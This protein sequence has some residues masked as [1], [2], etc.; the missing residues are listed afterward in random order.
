[1]IWI[2]LDVG[3]LLL[4]V[5]AEDMG[6]F[7]GRGG[8]NLVVLAVEGG[9][10]ASAQRADGGHFLSALILQRL[11]DLLVL[12]LS[13]LGVHDRSLLLVL[14]DLGASE[15]MLLFLVGRGQS[16]LLDADR[17]ARLAGVL[18]HLVFHLFGGHHQSL[19]V[20]KLTYDLRVLLG[21]LGLLNDR[22]I[23][24]LQLLLVLNL[25]DV[26]SVLGPPRVG[27]RRGLFGVVRDGAP[28]AGVLL[29]FGAL[30]RMS[31]IAAELRLVG[32]PILLGVGRLDHTAR[33]QRLLL[34]LLHVLLLFLSCLRVAIAEPIDF[35]LKLHFIPLLSSQDLV[36]LGLEIGCFGTAV[37][38]LEDVGVL[39]CVVV[40]ARAPLV[41]RWLGMSSLPVVAL[42]ASVSVVGSGGVI[43]RFHALVVGNRCTVETAGYMGDIG[44]RFLLA[45]GLLVEQMV[46]GRDVVVSV[47]FD[48]LDGVVG[49]E[50]VLVQYL[51]VDR[52]LN[53][54]QLL[55]R[56]QAIWLFVA[57]LP[58][59]GVLADL[60]N[61]ITLAWLRL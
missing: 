41:L 5:A 26:H 47:S 4:D 35:I 13:L 38:R 20:G 14:F 3:P 6:A 48:A 60:L 7:R 53:R 22:L 54:H 37:D 43:G 33:M 30:L 23:L 32:G 36:L 59:P 10:S 61:S 42:E 9:L 28:V 12:L 46:G 57:E 11:E 17:V 16:L 29:P 21:L 45:E 31:L 49:V 50:T 1:M 24:Q 34:L 39:V 40:G 15:D 2:G 56:E 19:A 44:E 25:D 51:L 55:A 52:V 18:L 8:R 27:V 58:V